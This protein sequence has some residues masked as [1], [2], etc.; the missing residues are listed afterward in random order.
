MFITLLYKSNLRAHMTYDTYVTTAPLPHTSHNPHDRAQISINPRS[1][2]CT[3]SSKTLANDRTMHQLASHPTDS[4]AT[5]ISSVFRLRPAAPHLRSHLRLRFFFSQG[6]MARLVSDAEPRHLA[7]SHH[8]RGIRRRGRK[9]HATQGEGVVPSI[10][11]HQS[12]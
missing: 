5:A 2:C 11:G 12:N 3:D 4:L 1:S 6:G 10:V 9:G 7:R 8:L